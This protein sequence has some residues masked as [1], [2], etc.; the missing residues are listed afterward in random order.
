MQKIGEG[1]WKDTEGDHTI[2][3]TT[4]AAIRNGVPVSGGGGPYRYQTE[5]L[6]PGA[7]P[8]TGRER[9]PS[10][11]QGEDWP[12][13]EEARDVGEDAVRKH[14]RKRIADEPGTT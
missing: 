12:T 13:E 4:C 1:T 11:E 5:I 10:S 3:V 2:Y 8:S 7:D 14:I 9:G 6:P